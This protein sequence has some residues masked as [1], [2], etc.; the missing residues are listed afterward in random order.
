MIKLKPGVIVRV[1]GHVYTG[2]IPEAVCPES[3]KPR[4]SK[5]KINGPA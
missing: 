3:L 5:A 4:K 2:S 1:G